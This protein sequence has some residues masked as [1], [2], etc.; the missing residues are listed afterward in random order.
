MPNLTLKNLIDS[1]PTNAPPATDADVLAWLETI[2]PK[3]DRC[4]QGDLIIISTKYDIE[5]VCEEAKADATTMVG[6]YKKRALAMG[7]Q[8][9][10]RRNEGIDVANP[11]TI[12]M[13]DLMVAA[14]LMPQAAEDEIIAAATKN[15]P[16]WTGAID[17]RDPTDAAETARRLHDVAAARA[18]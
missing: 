14:N 3:V 4:S 7:Y 11:N 17:W 2:V 8:R 15:V 12:P 18:L 16:R 10:M 13:L 6:S 1:D 9:V 5:G